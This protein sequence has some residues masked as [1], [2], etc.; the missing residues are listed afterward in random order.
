MSA[1][2]E[3]LKKLN[4]AGRGGEIRTY[5]RE[6]AGK[7]ESVYNSIRRDETLS[8]SGKLQNL[9]GAYL[10]MR[11][12]V[13]REVESRA[14]RVMGAD[15]DDASSVFGTKGIPGDPASL[16]ISRRDASDR[17]ASITSREELR[18]LLR[19]ATRSGDEVLARAVAERAL[20]DEDDA[21]MHLFLADRPNLDAAAERLWNARQAEA[22]SFGDIVA[23][24]ELYP[25]E[26][27]GMTTEAIESVAQGQTA[28]AR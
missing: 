23:A 6:E 18:E 9:A 13:D 14:T 20:E 21:T 27:Y 10:A 4:A 5:L 19:R 15:R 3:N 1:F 25:G 28:G 7:V 24:S 11:V 22:N 8:E 16:T 12:R 2:A 26:L 17:V